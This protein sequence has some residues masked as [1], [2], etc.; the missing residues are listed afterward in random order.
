[1]GEARSLQRELN[2]ITETANTSTSEG[3]SDV[4]KGELSVILYRTSF[5]ILSPIT[6]E[7]VSYSFYFYF[8]FLML[9]YAF[10]FRGNNSFAL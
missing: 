7:P 10:G 1:M 8:S 9:L 5:G 2:R 3:L 6:V 4:L